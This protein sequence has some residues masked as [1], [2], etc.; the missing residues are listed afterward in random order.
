[1]LQTKQNT[2]LLSEVIEI[3]KCAGSE[4]MKFYQLIGLMV[5]TKADA[6]PVTQ[7]DLSAHHI[8]FDGLTKISDDLIIS[9]ES[10]AGK[11]Q[12]LTQRKFWLVDPLDGTRD[13]V[14]GRETFCV[15]IAL[16]DQGE[17]V[18]GVLYSP[19]LNEVFSAEKNHGSYLN[20]Q[21]IFNSSTRLDLKAVA[22]GS[23]Q[24]SQRMQ[25]FLK[26][27]KFQELCRFGSALKFGY[28][29]R[30]DV[31]LYPRFGETSEWDTAAGQIICQEAGCSILDIHTLKVMRYAK[32]N[33][34]NNGF[35]AVRN[36]LLDTFRK[37]VESLR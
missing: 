29:S 25:N 33:F 20:G 21:K 13:F 22:G 26:I 11:A 4:I 2:P 28:L 35:I 27:S 30:V 31:D 7:A 19:V 16:I 18:L 3:A 10:D 6:S 34:R 8:I 37:I 1:M 24:P 9:E 14:A 36:D 17:P 32:Q 15:S 12:D 23:T 5:Q